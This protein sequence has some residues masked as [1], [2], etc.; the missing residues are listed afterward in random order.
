MSLNQETILQN[1]KLYEEQKPLYLLQI[2]KAQVDVIVKFDVV[3]GVHPQTDEDVYEIR[4][5]GEPRNSSRS[6]Y[7]YSKNAADIRAYIS[8]KCGCSMTNI[9]HVYCNGIF[10]EDFIVKP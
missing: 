5:T 2:G 1:K 6:R 3:R 8:A 4:L 9:F 7:L 10:N